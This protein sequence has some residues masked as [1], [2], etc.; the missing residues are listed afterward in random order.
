MTSKAQLE[1]TG[2]ALL[3]PYL[4]HKMVNLRAQL[5]FASW[6]HKQLLRPNQELKGIAKGKRAFLLA[7]GPSLK[8][9][10]VKLLKN[11]DCFSISNFF[12]HDDL[13]TVLP[14]L[15]FFAPYHKP[16]VLNNYLEWLNE[17]DAKLPAETNIV[18]GHTTRELV[19]KHD[20]FPNRKV[21]YL[22]LE[23]M[24]SGNFN[25]TKP[26]MGPQTGPIM[27]IPWLLYMGYSKIYLL[28][29]DHTIFRDYGKTTQNFYSK[30]EDSREN[31]TNGDNWPDILTLLKFTDRT[32][33]Q[34]AYYKK[35]AEKL[36]VE[37]INLSQDSWLNIF[38]KKQLNDVISYQT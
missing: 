27:M 1:E 4:F 21:F 23:G 25:I 35:T 29:C 34:Y 14:K 16:L 12:L 38:E 9:D 37:I 36:N 28:G 7:T 8:L 33:R 31:A 17:G 24:F 5:L 18:L 6:T 3:P 22:F 32:F 30:E 10:N 26:I 19:K 15:H 20:L 11:E 13:Y 2:A